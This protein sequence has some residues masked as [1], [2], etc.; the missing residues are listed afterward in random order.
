MFSCRLQVM[1][2][3]HER[4]TIARAKHLSDVRKVSVEQ[5]LK[6][7][8]LNDEVS[9]KLEEMKEQEV[10]TMRVPQR[11]SKENAWTKRNEKTTETTETTTTEETTNERT[12]SVR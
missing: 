7:V 10:P 5:T 2:L 11:A 4:Y 12:N 6:S 1:R 9:K 8:T 3:E